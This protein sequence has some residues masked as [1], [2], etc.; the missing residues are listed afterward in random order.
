MTIVSVTSDLL[1]PTEAINFCLP[2]RYDQ[3]MLGLSKSVDGGYISYVSFGFVVIHN[4]Q[5]RND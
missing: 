2:C 4:T 3:G 1:L 5:V